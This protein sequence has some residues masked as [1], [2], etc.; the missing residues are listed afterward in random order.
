MEE[1]Q[2]PNKAQRKGFARGFQQ[3]K[4]LLFRGIVSSLVGD[5]VVSLF[6]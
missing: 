1:E 3:L 4:D 5:Q 2:S 6:K